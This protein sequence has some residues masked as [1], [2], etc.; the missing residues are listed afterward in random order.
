LSTIALGTA[1]G[2]MRDS[3]PVPVD[4]EALQQIAETWDEALGRLKAFVER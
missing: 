1:S 4:A 3:T 2:Q